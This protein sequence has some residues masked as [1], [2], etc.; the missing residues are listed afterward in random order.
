VIVDVNTDEFGARVFTQGGSQMKK[1][2]LV[3]ALSLLTAP[4]FAQAQLS[5]DQDSAMSASTDE[6]MLSNEALTPL[7]EQTMDDLALR[8]WPPGHEQPGHGHPGHGQPGHGHGGWYFTC[9]ARDFTGRQFW[10]QGW[11]QYQAQRNALYGCQRA[12]LPIPIRTCR[13][14]SCDRSWQ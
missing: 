10:G 8:P 7:D 6:Q 2:L 4:A 5:N 13:V 1:I 3:A 12:S 11:N 9:Y 14:V